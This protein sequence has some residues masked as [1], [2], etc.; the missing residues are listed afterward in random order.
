MKILYYMCVYAPA[1]QFGGVVTWANQL[2]E[3]LVGLNHQLEVFT[4]NCGLE[5]SSD[6][7]LGQPIKYNNVTVNYFPYHKNYLGIQSPQM[8]TAIFSRIQ[9]FDIVHISGVWQ[10]TSYSACQ[11]AKKFNI[12]YISTLHGSLSPYSWSQGFLK[13]SLYYLWQENWNVSNASAIHYTAQQELE[14]CRWLNLPGKPIIIPNG[15]DPDFWKPDPIRSKQWRKKHGFQEDDFLL[16]N[17]GR[18]HH[19]KGLDLLPSV[20]EKIRDLKWKMIFVGD[21]DDGTKKQLISQF[22][23]LNLL[24]KIYFLPKCEPKDLC[25]I[26]SAV[27]LFVLPSRHENFGNV[28]IEALSCGCP[29]IISDKVGI[30]KEIKESKMGWV[31]KRNIKDWANQLRTLISNRQLLSPITITS[32]EWVQSKFSIYQTAKQMVLSYEDT[33]NSHRNRKD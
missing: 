10:P 11:A 21:D 4:T 14:E 1:W 8:E 15:L 23:A 18:L 27:N 7:P 33:I 32:R 13:K 5:H 28:V 17:I 29:V 24:D 12:P 26:Y 3:N 25:S 9:E 19:K 30:C 2:C 6:I 20:L 22:K 31:L 16:V